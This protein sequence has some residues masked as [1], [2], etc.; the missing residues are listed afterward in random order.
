MLKQI[1]G[2]FGGNGFVLYLADNLYFI[3]RLPGETGTHVRARAAFACNQV[4][5]LHPQLTS[6]TRVN[7]PGVFALF[8]DLLHSS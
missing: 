6:L 3:P 8:C 1:H 5:L 7:S 2:A 4:I